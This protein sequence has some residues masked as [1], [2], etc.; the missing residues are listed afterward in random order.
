MIDSVLDSI[1]TLFD[2][3]SIPFEMVEVY[4][5]VTSIWDAFPLAL[6]AV[7]I[8]MFMLSTFYCVLRM[9]F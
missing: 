2:N 5:S 1:G 9:L 4:K 3:L 8:G 7:L 6:K